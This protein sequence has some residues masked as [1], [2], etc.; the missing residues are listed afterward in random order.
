[1]PSLYLAHPF[2]LLGQYIIQHHSEKNREKRR[3][4]RA[5]FDVASGICAV[6]EMATVQGFYAKIHHRGVDAQK[7]ERRKRIPPRFERS[8]GEGVSP[9]GEHE[10]K[11]RQRAE[12][13]Q[14][15]A[16]VVEQRLDV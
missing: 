1:M 11:H 10:A 14:G 5:K 16:D 9:A 7:Y 8:I 6:K 4:Q 15:E 13:R 3:A 12:R 2:L